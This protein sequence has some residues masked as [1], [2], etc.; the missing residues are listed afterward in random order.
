VAGHSQRRLA[1]GDLEAP[2]IELGYAGR[3]RLLL[4]NAHRDASGIPM[5]NANSDPGLLEFRGPLGH[6]D[7]SA[8]SVIHR[9]D[10]SQ[11]VQ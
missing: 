6:C 2:M 8:T 7:W 9:W 5:A 10:L 1:A 4:V 3:A 11:T